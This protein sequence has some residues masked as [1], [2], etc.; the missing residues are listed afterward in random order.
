MHCMLDLE[1]LS[2]YP[3]ATILTIGAVKFD[4]YTLD[5][6]GDEL[7]LRIDVN[8]QLEIGRHVSEDT[9]TW[10]GKQDPIVREEA[11]GDDNRVS[12]DDFYRQLNRFM[13]GAG[14]IWCQGPHFD[15]V[16]LENLYKQKGWPTPWQ[17]WQISD[18]R[19]V[20][21]MHGDPRKKE[22]GKLH[23]ALED[24]RSQARALQRIHN[25]LG[26][27]PRGYTNTK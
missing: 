10:W 22:Q 27:K 11:L 13:V 16:I 24:C 17:Y 8:E 1:T 15:I 5:A 25:D 7:Y 4:P 9:L 12:L 18:S 26:L 21:K 6:F 19:T 14:D 20:F 23:N 3:D 2:T